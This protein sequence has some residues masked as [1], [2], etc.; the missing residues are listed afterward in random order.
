MIRIESPWSSLPHGPNIIAPR[1]RGLTWTPV[2][3]SG[4]S[5]MVDPLV[6]RMGS[7]TSHGSDGRSAVFLVGDLL[8]PLGLRAVLALSQAVPHGE[9]GHEAVGGGAVPVPL[10]RRAPNR[11][12]GID[13]H[14]VRAPRLRQ[15]DALGDMQRLA[16][17]VPVPGGAGPGREVDGVDL[18]AGLRAGGDDVEVNDAGEPLSR[19]GDR[20]LRRE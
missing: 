14:D 17:G 9:V 6:V 1:H 5:C 2:R 8:A 13:A 16:V 19:S 12:T 4:R 7:T 10:P 20:R 18:A 3:P 15:A 11:A